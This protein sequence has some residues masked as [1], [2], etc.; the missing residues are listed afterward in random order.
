MYCKNCKRHTDNTFP[1][2]ISPDLKEYNQRKFKMCYL[3]D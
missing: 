2:K 3:F 1:K